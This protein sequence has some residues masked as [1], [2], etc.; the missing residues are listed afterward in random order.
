MTKALEWAE[1]VEAWRTSGQSAAEFCVER[2]YTSKSLQWWASHLRRK[3]PRPQPN[4]KRVTLARVVR[5]PLATWSPA[6]SP[7]VVQVGDGRVEVVSGADGTVLSVVF[8]TLLA[9]SR[10]TRR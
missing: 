3:V 5:R 6:P 2:D 8:E 7:I 4:G 10:R 9:V 1:R